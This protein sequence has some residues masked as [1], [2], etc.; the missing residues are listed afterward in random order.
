MNTIDRLERWAELAKTD[1]VEALKFRERECQ[2]DE[3]FANLCEI[4]DRLIP[5]IIA[6][7]S[8]IIYSLQSAHNESDP[9]IRTALID[10]LKEEMID[11]ICCRLN[12]ELDEEF[13]EELD[14]I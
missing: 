6:E 2:I 5:T 1:P 11:R 3:R 8:D 4:H 14:D 12:E 7:S 13:D 10:S 9:R